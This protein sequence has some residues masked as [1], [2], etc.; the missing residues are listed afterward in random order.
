MLKSVTRPIN[1]LLI[2]CLV[3]G[4]LTA[5]GSGTANNSTTG[6]ETSIN[7]G[8][9]S[10]TGSAD[11]AQA[12]PAKTI[13][14]L[15]V[16]NPNQAS[17]LAITEILKEYQAEV[18]PNFN[19]EINSIIDRPTQEQ[20]LKTLVAS[21]DIPEWFEIDPNQYAEQLIDKGLLINIE[22]MLK[23]MNVY[24]KYLPSAMEYQKT[25]SG[26][27]YTLPIENNIEFFW[28]N[29]KMFQDAGVTEPTTFDEFLE[30][31]EKLKQSGFT[32][33]AICGKDGWPLMRYLSFI[34]FRMTGNEYL[35]KVASGEASM[36]DEI[37]MAGLNFVKELGKYFQE[38]FANTDYTSTLNLFL[39]GKVAIFNMGTW[40]LQNFINPGDA[41]KDNI[42]Y[43]KLPLV[44]GDNA[45]TPDDGYT[46]SGIGI[47]M[48][49][50]GFDATTEDFIKFMIDRYPEKAIEKGF[51]PPIE[52]ELAADAPELLKKVASDMA[53]VK[54][55]A[56]LWDVKLDAVTKELYISELSGVAMGI[57]TPEDFAAKSDKSVKASLNN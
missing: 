13:Q 48:T 2:L 45:T 50:A 52:S 9:T 56:H 55:V 17:M 11:N 32:P 10:N 15:S 46:N 40:E 37:G 38:G 3:I 12:K 8:S 14:Y 29:K 33:I 36:S 7:N 35:T 57:I 19:I 51:L 18:N 6:E 41:M 1:V 21:G 27:I 23:D 16:R 26:K 24:D 54:T 47:A 5:C 42:G 44:D 31:C 39:G 49:V 43:F 30:V 28:Y 34:P 4:I 22:Q 53:K 25:A 20:K